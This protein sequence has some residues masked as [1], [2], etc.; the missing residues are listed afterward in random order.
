[1]EAFQR[2]RIHCIKN[3]D[4]IQGNEWKKI[5]TH[6]VSQY[7]KINSLLFQPGFN[8]KIH[9]GPKQETEFA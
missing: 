5:N 6:I 9:A 7:H 1:M 8:I 2:G 3:Y 4:V